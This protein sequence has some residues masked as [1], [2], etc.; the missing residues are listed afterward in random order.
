MNKAGWR[1]RRIT[2]PD[3]APGVVYFAYNPKTGEAFTS[4]DVA[5]L[6]RSMTDAMT[7]DFMWHLSRQSEARDE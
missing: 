2:L 3:P 1:S 7:T 6:L 5:K 4:S